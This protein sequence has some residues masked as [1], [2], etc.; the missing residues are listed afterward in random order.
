M[1]GVAVAI[2]IFV[3]PT[4]LPQRLT[5]TPSAAIAQAPS[6][7]GIGNATSTQ[8]EE[9]K[10]DKLDLWLNKLAQAE[11]TG[12]ENIKILDVN[13]RYSYGCL[14]FQMRTFLSYAE[15]YDIEVTTDDI[16]DCNLQKRLAKEM[17]L[18]NHSNWRHWFNSAKYKVGLPPLLSTT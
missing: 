9:P 7:N 3:N 6:P 14:Q 1:G 17:I 2:F 15:R 8:S 11:S 12:R 16:Y 10:A 4:K 18:E 13:G 5:I